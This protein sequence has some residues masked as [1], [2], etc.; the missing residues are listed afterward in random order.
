MADIPIRVETRLG[1]RDAIQAAIT[2]Q[3]SRRRG[4]LV[5]GGE[6]PVSSGIVWPNEAGG[7][8]EGEGGSEPIAAAGAVQGSISKLYWA[9]ARPSTDP[10]VT[11]GGSRASIGRMSIDGALRS[12]MGDQNFASPSAVKH[13]LG[14]LVHKLAAGLATGA[15]AFYDLCFNYLA[16]GM[17]FGLT[18]GELNCD[19]CR[20]YG[21]RFNLCDTAVKVVNRQA[22]GNWFYSPEYWNITNYCHQFLTGGDFRWYDPFLAGPAST[23]IYKN[24]TNDGTVVGTNNTVSGPY[25]YDVMGIVADEH[26]GATLLVKQETGYNYFDNYNF[27]GGRVKH[28]YTTSQPMF[29]ISGHSRLSLTNGFRTLHPGC[30]RW[31]S[32]SSTRSRVYLHN[33]EL[34]AATD[35]AVDAEDYF[36]PALGAGVCDGPCEVVVRDCWTNWQRKVF[37]YEQIYNE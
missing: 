17:Q 1:T 18:T 9:G 13:G 28:L 31:H 15:S 22:L 35:V 37:D 11:F 6:I 7:W 29:D 10:I 4:V 30:I 27:I 33:V 24:P 20:I 34:Y 2:A 21:P 32:H 19:T 25:N 12:Q 16:V 36:G 8:M 14:L 3:K 23:F 26:A 5:G